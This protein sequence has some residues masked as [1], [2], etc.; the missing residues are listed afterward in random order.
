M[1]CDICFTITVKVVVKHSLYDI[2]KIV[3]TLKDSNK[4]RLICVKSPDDG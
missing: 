1:N 3:H 2:E 4:E